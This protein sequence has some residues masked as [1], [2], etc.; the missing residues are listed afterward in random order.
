MIFKLVP[1]IGEEFTKKKE[2]LTKLAQES[3]IKSEEKIAK[4]DDEYIRSIQKEIDN[5]TISWDYRKDMLENALK[6]L[7]KYN[8]IPFGNPVYAEISSEDFILPEKNEEEVEV[9][10][11]TP[12]KETKPVEKNKFHIRKANVQKQ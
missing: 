9:P 8:M 10:K 4:M 1:D 5:S 11:E 12:E 6:I 2:H 7:E 3:F